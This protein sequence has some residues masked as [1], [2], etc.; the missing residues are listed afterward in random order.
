MKRPEVQQILDWKL[1][2]GLTFAQV[3][4]AEVTPCSANRIWRLRSRLGYSSAFNHTYTSLGQAL[5]MMALLRAEDS[6]PKH[7]VP[8]LASLT[9]YLDEPLTPLPIYIA[10]R[11]EKPSQ[12]WVAQSGTDL[13]TQLG[14]LDAGLL[15]AAVPILIE[16]LCNGSPSQYALSCAATAK[17]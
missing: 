2:K 5:V 17:A 11:L 15:I 16:H 10:L 7:S 6:P 8:M 12:Y 13:Y 1:A 3:Y 14:R 9:Q 4:I